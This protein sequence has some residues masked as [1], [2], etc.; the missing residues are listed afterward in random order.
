MKDGTE[1]RLLTPDEFETLVSGLT[2]AQIDKIIATL[3][4]NR[5]NCSFGMG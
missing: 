4:P 2:A 5:T 3:E 1:I